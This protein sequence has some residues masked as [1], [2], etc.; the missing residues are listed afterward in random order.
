LSQEGERYRPLGHGMHAVQVPDG[1]QAT[2]HG[3]RWA[4]QLIPAQNR[5]AGMAI[6]YAR[7]YRS[8]GKRW[9]ILMEHKPYL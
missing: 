2:Q 1:L 6:G 3:V 5:T 4:L 9:W 7:E 8:E